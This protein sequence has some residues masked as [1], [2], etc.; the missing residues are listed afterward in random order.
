MGRTAVLCRRRNAPMHLGWTRTA[1]AHG[2]GL[3]YQSAGS[4]M[5]AADASYGVVS[6]GSPTG[7]MGPAGP[8][9]EHSPPPESGRRWFAR[10]NERSASDDARED[11]QAREA[12]SLVLVARFSSHR[13]SRLP[14]GRSAPSAD[15]GALARTDPSVGERRAERNPLQGDFIGAMSRCTDHRYRRRSAH[16]PAST[17]P[18]LFAA[19]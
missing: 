12:H 6:V 3:R 11:A 18:L 17:S 15:R 4:M 9:T 16:R 8:G 5:R 7:R 14:G 13:H 10:V 1:A 19:R 2:S